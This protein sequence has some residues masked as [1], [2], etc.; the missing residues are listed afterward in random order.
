MT[1]L[2]ALTLAQARDGLR[3]KQFSA[4]EL[5]DAHLAAIES[6][7]ALNAFVLETPERA[8]DMARASDARLAK[9]QGGPLE[10][11]PLG[12]KDL[13]CTD[14]V[15]TT[16]CSHILE[17][18]VPHLRIDRHRQSVAR[19]RGHARQA[20]LRRIRHGLVERDLAFRSGGVAMAPARRRHKARARRFLGRLGGGGGGA[21]VRRRHRHRHRRLDPPAGGVLRH[22]R[23]K[24]HLRPL[25]ALGHRRVRVV[26]R[27]GR[28]V[29]AHRARLRDPAALD[30]GAGSEG[31]DLRRSAGARLRESRRRLGQG[32]AHRHSEGI[33]RARHGGGNRDAVAAGRAVAQGRRRANSSTSRC[34]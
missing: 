7:R 6:A 28:A 12:I 19:R 15:R 1:D 4:S 34:R 3:A 5:T 21:S 20:Q 24:A 22:R 25:L 9:G 11:L 10:G 18:F 2:T 14:G 29:R 26:A 13:F 17:N 8:R 30:G 31:Y 16:A 33:P 32:H 23:T 27:P